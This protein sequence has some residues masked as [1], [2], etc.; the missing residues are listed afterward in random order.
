MKNFLKKLTTERVWLTGNT[1]LILKYWL[2]KNGI[3]CEP[4]VPHSYC[5]PC[6]TDFMEEF[7]FYMTL[8]NALTVVWMIKNKSRLTD[9][10]KGEQLQ[11]GSG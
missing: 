4:C 6:Q 3:Q 10:L 5:P 7:W 11:T 1:L 8:F 9:R 2:D